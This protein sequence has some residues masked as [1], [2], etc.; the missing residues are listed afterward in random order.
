MNFGNGDGSSDEF[1]PDSWWAYWHENEQDDR[2][3]EVVGDEPH[4][5]TIDSDQQQEFAEILSEHLF[6]NRWTNR[7]RFF[8]ERDSN[9]GNES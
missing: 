4:A 5:G 8:L 6:G 2:A 9:R 1:G 3:Y 7:V